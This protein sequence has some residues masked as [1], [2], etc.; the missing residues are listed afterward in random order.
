[1]LI[2]LFKFNMIVIYTHV[3][4]LYTSTQI[5]NTKNHVSIN[6]YLDHRGF[7]SCSSN[8]ADNLNYNAI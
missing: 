5:T 2:G 8:T 4:V 3:R 1:M 6:I 7:L